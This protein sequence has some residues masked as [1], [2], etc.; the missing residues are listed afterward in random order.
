[1]PDLEAKITFKFYFS[2]DLPAL[3]SMLTC[4][5]N[6]GNSQQGDR[7]GFFKSSSQ[8]H[9]FQTFLERAVGQDEPVV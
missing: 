3:A 5:G 9:L 1:M 8:K 4:T 6:L 7:F 2:K